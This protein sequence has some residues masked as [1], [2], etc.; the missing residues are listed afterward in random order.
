MYLEVPK[1]ATCSYYYIVIY[2][3]LRCV[4]NE[5]C[6]YLEVLK[7]ATCSRLRYVQRL[8]L[9][10]EGKST[11]A[12]NHGQGWKELKAV[13]DHGSCP[14]AAEG[15]G[16]GGRK[17]SCRCDRQLLRKGGQSEPGESDLHVVFFYR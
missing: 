4:S 16:G 3:N 13:R 12:A 14:A 8:S 6:R 11:A 2:K 9:A 1:L 5:Y 15:G 10:Y 17:S 7:L